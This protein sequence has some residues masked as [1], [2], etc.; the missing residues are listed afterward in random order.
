MPWIDTLGR[1]GEIGLD[2]GCH[3]Q[4]ASELTQ[5]VRRKQPHEEGRTEPSSRREQ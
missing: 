1:W 5:V 4:V 2:W 3:S